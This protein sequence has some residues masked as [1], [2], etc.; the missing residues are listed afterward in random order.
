MHCG[1]YNPFHAF[2]VLVIDTGE[3]IVHINQATIDID[4]ILDKK[5]ADY[6]GSPFSNY[7]NQLSDSLSLH[8]SLILKI[9]DQEQSFYMEKES[10]IAKF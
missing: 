5:P 1:R 6:V 7:Y 9:L 8:K 10:L 2:G 4:G 3:K